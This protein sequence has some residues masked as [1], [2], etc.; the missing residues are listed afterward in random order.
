MVPPDLGGFGRARSEHWLLAEPLPR[1]ANPRRRLF[2]TLKSVS[3]SD[4]KSHAWPRVQDTRFGRNSIATVQGSTATEKGYESEQQRLERGAVGGGIG[5]G[6]M[7]RRA[8]YP[9]TGPVLVCP[10]GG[11]AVDTSPWTGH[12]QEEASRPTEEKARW[13]G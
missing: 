13:T 3:V 2:D 6:S 4:G 9:L 12:I 1:L 11:F 7:A 8:L 5:G 10:A